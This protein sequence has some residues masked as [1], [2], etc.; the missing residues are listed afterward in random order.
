MSSAV[1]FDLDGTL[2]DSK[3]GI[4]RCLRYAFE[5]LSGAV[6]RPVSLPPDSELGWV[7]GP[8]LRSSL[9]L[10]A[11]AENE[12]A[13]L[14]FYRERYA[15]TGAFENEV[16]AGIPEALDALAARGMR[17]FVATSK[18]KRDAEIILRHFGLSARFEAI[19]GAE[20]DGG[21]ADKTELI[22]H[23]LSEAG[24]AAGR[25]RITMIGDRKFD[26][27]GAKNNQL[28]AIG[29]L[30]GYGGRGE[31]TDAGADELADG[32][33]DIGRLVT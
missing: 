7:I 6:G 21:R 3:L 26:M 31:L 15:T 12:E 10:L 22:A 23:V 27:I 5:R 24:L 32:P 9:A 8:P 11:G 33:G 17:L 25:D 1:L 14:G 2:T 4:L 19:H 18:N 29:A 13:A 28:E 20:A 16:Y 30:W